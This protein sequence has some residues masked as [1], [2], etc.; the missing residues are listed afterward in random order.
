MSY[1]V[2]IVDDELPNAR[3]LEHSLRQHYFCLMAASCSEALRLLAQHDVAVIIAHQQMSGLSGIE[4]LKRTAEYEPDAVRILL[5]QEAEPEVLVEAINS[6][7]VDLYLSKPWDPEDLLLYIGQAVQRYYKNK[8]RHSLVVA[9]EC[10]RTRLQAMKSGSVR[11]MANVLKLSDEYLFAH[12]SRVSKWAGLVGEKFGL[13]E[14]LRSDLEAAGLLHDLGTIVS[15]RPPKDD[16]AIIKPQQDRAAQ[17]LS[18]VPELRDVAD[19]IRYQN[20]NYDGSGYPLGLVGEQIPITSRILS[21]ANE[22]DLLT[23]PRNSLVALSHT[24]AIKELQERAYR[25][26]DPQVVQAFSDLAAD[27]LHEA[28]DLNATP[29]TFELVTAAI[30]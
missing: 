8:R 25:D 20:A 4:L 17:I 24:A 30:N 1:K 23:S 15:N 21:V 22:Y 3:L 2:L 10:L 28:H 18:C 13:S 29:G 14:E 5:S 19:I 11:A 9:N 27:G 26:F 12:G 16:F 6:D 7:Q